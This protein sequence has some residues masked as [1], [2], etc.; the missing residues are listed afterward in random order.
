MYMLFNYQQIKIHFLFFL[1]KYDTYLFF[2]FFAALGFSCGV[3]DLVPQPGI[4][5]KPLY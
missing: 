3:W 2:F 4:K 1:F 5:P